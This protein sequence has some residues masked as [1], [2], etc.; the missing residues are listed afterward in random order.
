MNVPINLVEGVKAGL[1]RDIRIGIL[2]KVTVDKLV[3]SNLLRIVVA[4]KKSGK[5]RR[6]VDFKPLNMSCPRQTHPV[7]PLF[8]R[9]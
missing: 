5:P 1:A 2:R 6:R 4:L 3:T 7:E 8:Y 9:L